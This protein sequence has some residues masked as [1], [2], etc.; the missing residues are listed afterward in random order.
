M[1]NTKSKR[2]QNT[3][4]NNNLSTKPDNV[5]TNNDLDDI[6]DDVDDEG[7]KLEMQDMTAR[8]AINVKLI[9][10]YWVRNYRENN[11]Y[12]VNESQIMS[13]DI[14]SEIC[15]YCII[16]YNFIYSYGKYEM[17]YKNII[18]NG[19]HYNEDNL[20]FIN[21]NQKLMSHTYNNTYGQCNLEPIFEGDNKYYKQL[22][23]SDG[24]ASEHSFILVNNKEIYCVGRNHYGQL[25]INKK[26]YAE[27]YPILI[28]N[29]ILIKANIISI[30]CGYEHSLFLTLKGILFGCGNNKNG[31]IGVGK[32]IQKCH[33]I[34]E[35]KRF[36]NR[37]NNSAT[38]F[39]NVV[40][41]KI[42]CTR[43]TSF[44]LDENGRLFAFG[45]NDFSLLA[46]G[47]A[48]HSVSAQHVYI[49]LLIPTLQR[50]IK[51]SPK[52]IKRIIDVKVGVCHALVLTDKHYVYAWG[53][54]KACGITQIGIQDYPTIIGPHLQMFYNNNPSN[55]QSMKP[56]KVKR[57]SCGNYHSIC[58][59][60]DGNLVVFGK[61]ENGQCF[62]KK[63]KFVRP[64][65]IYVKDVL[66]NKGFDPDFCDLYPHGSFDSTLIGVETHN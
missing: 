32:P 15:R 57:I 40:I 25:G 44:C 26:T 62:L 12:I 49:P 39:S 48:H 31:Q 45:Q 4:N 63:S 3:I 66:I 60:F 59:T 50:L 55:S 6:N 11:V 7:W 61:N 37:W 47:E 14:L 30:K 20:F 41:K 16:S 18:H 65:K 36:Q 1:G 29:P 53:S 10:Q 27:P 51:K 54:A 23:I 64:T 22:L 5:T 34:T 56:Y 46:F 38:I 9:I 2:K 33:S 43:R 24:F 19:I 21:T 13:R 35:I 42:A 17:E 52:T 28:N 8:H 58:N